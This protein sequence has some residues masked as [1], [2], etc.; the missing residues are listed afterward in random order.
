MVSC[1]SGLTFGPFAIGG[2]SPS[3]T[4]TLQFLSHTAIYSDIYSSTK[5]ISVFACPTERNLGIRAHLILN[6]CSLMHLINII[7]SG[8]C[9]RCWQGTESV[10]SCS[11]CV[12]CLTAWLFERFLNRYSRRLWATAIEQLRRRFRYRRQGN[13]SGSLEAEPRCT[14]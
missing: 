6:T 3:H 9:V 10:S 1:L 7:M 14:C 13:S 5:N 2:T 8:T 11:I 12:A 4:F